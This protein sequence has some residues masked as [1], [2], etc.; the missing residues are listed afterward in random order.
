MI[1]RIQAIQHIAFIFGIATFTVALIFAANDK[2]LTPSMSLVYRL[3][4]IN[5]WICGAVHLGCTFAVEFIEVEV[6][7]EGEDFDN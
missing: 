2:S 1:K 6:E 3:C 5:T 7:V 4:N